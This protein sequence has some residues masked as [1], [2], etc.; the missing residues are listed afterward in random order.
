MVKSLLSFI[1][2]K[3]PLRRRHP[4]QQSR[5]VPLC[6]CSP[7]LDAGSFWILFIPTGRAHALLFLTSSMPLK[8]SA[9]HLLFSLYFFVD[10][11]PLKAFGTFFSLGCSLVEYVLT[12]TFKIKL[13]HV[14][15]WYILCTDF[16]PI[17]DLSFYYL[18][19]VLHRADLFKILMKFSL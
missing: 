10:K 8:R 1:T 4:Q 13:G 17:C 19:R 18:D 6:P 2:A 3:L 5:G 16:L 9:F 14:F 15:I 7:A 12:C 11:V